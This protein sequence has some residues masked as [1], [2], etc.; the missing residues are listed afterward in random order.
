MPVIGLF[1]VCRLSACLICWVERIAHRLIL[2]LAPGS[3]RSSRAARKQTPGLAPGSRLDERVARRQTLGLAP[4]SLCLDQSSS[5]ANSRDSS[6][7]PF[8]G[9]AA[10]RQT[11]GLAPGSLNPDLWFQLSLAAESCISSML[12]WSSYRSYSL[13]WSSFWVQHQCILHIC[14]S[15]PKWSLTNH[16][17]LP[18]FYLVY[19]IDS[20]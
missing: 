8:N 7:L 11:L 2:G 20:W 4:G 12:S 1:F 18:L 13:K 16:H 15:P 17:P 19:Y 6:W 3:L 9:R 5:Q 10:R 14:Y